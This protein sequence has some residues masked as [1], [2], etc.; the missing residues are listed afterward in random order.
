MENKNKKDDLDAVREVVE[1]IRSFSEEEQKRIIRWS[2]EKLGIA[3]VDTDSK[4][5]S[6]ASDGKKEEIKEFTGIQLAK[7]ADIKSFVEG[8]NPRTD[9]HFAAVVAYYH[10][11][12]A[13]DKKDSITKQD[14]VDATRL[15]NWDRLPRPDQTLVNTASSG[16][17]DKVSGSPG[18]YHL[19]S[20]GENLVA[21]VLPSG[22][23]GKLLKVVKNKT[24]RKTKKKKK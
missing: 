21:M 20:V 14:L 15:A 6:F 9:K 3:L 8:K 5:S 16:L 22:E 11:F 18:H 10:Q 23:G 17:L 4:S 12:E 1:A 19:N 24:K 2:C 7:S 13:K